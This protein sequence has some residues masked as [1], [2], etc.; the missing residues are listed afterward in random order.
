VLLVKAKLHHLA[1]SLKRVTTAR[2]FAIGWQKKSTIRHHMSPKITEPIFFSNYW[3][4]P[5]I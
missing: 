2:Y 3:L 4:Q 1:A 5:T